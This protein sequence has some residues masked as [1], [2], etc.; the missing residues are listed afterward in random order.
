MIT[1]DSVVLTLVWQDQTV[2][3][4]SPTMDNPTI[5]NRETPSDGVLSRVPSSITSS[6]LPSRHESEE[7][8]A[9]TFYH[10]DD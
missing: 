1:S 7:A 9:E 10:Y 8:Y 2:H 5:D 3:V 4:D 6:M